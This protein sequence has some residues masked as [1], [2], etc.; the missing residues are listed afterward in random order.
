MLTKEQIEIHKKAKNV[1]DLH[2]AIGKV[3][4]RREYAFSESLIPLIMI[5]GELI[6]SFVPEEQHEVAVAMVSVNLLETVK[7]F[8]FIAKSNNDASCKSALRDLVFA[9]LTGERKSDD[10]TEN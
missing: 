2:V 7:V 3:L 8:N 5:A 4:L 9:M 6:I 1:T 10:A